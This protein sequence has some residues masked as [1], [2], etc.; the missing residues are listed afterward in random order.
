MVANTSDDNPALRAAAL[1]PIDTHQSPS[2][3]LYQ[4]VDM[5]LTAFPDDTSVASGH[6]GSLP[7][8][9]AASIGDVQVATRILSQVGR[10]LISC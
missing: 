8:H 9:F 10:L 1:A 2:L 7:L 5:I 3:T 4:D 6:D